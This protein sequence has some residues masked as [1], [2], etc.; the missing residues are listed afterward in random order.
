MAF[1]LERTHLE[2]IMTIRLLWPALLCL[3]LA[4]VN[5]QVGR[6]AQP[7]GVAPGAAATEASPSDQAG[8]KA[9]YLNAAQAPL[10]QQAPLQA[11]MKQGMVQ[12]PQ[13]G[14]VQAPQVVTCTVMVP[15]VTYQTTTIT[16]MVP[17]A[18]VRQQE[19]Q[20]C[21]LVPETKMIN[22]VQTVAVPEQR[23]MEQPY[24]VCRLTM[25]TASRQVTVMVPQMET[26]Q[27][28]RTVCRPVA[29][30]VMKTVCRDMG[31]YQT[32]SYVDC[33]GCTLTC[34]VYVPNIVSEQVPVTVYKPQ[35]VEE[36][37]T[38][39]AVT[40]R[41]EQRTIT[42]QIPKPVYETRMRQINYTV[43]VPR[44]IER[45][46]PQTTMRPVMESKTVN[47]TVMVPREVQKQVTVPVCTMVPK[48]VSYTLPPPC[49]PCDGC[50]W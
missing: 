35:M 22:T 33:C 48:Q 40:C 27:G 47:Y 9:G 4:A 38:Y 26:R 15:Q 16:Q 41:P 14:A 20:V 39:Q 46:I 36:Q 2:T 25:E 32:Q 12:A 49:P 34:Q 7:A 24:T 21:R 11:P 43:C 19:V 50:G 28:V 1:R 6:T 17:T 30:Q 42:Q 3:A 31:G 37:F 44:Q 18:E 10:M 23:T 8:T 5:P 29:T 45:Q 13:K